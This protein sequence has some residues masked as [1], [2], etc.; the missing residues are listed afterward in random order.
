MC[1]V[2]FHN[3][4]IVSSFFYLVLCSRSVLAKNW[5]LCTQLATS[6]CKICFRVSKFC[7]RVAIS[8]T[9]FSFLRADLRG[10]WQWD[11]WSAYSVRSRG[12]QSRWLGNE[13]GEGA[14]AATAA[15]A[16]AAAMAAVTAAVTAAAAVAEVRAA[17]TAGE[18]YEQL[19]GMIKYLEF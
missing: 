13:D 12:G 2:D 5:R 6:A 3:F 4:L 1:S 15:A 8:S 18:A 9:V 14:A 10:Y 19:S 7:S 17:G 16:S 11:F